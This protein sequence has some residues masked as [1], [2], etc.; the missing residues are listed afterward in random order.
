MAE[1]NGSVFRR[2]LRSAERLSERAML[3]G[4]P[5]VN[6]PLSKSRALLVWVTCPDQ[7]LGFGVAMTF[8]HP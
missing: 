6:T 3:R 4:S 7:R 2:R 8:F 5:R 1:R